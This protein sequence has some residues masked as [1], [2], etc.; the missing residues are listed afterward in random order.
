M[1]NMKHIGID[2]GGTSIKGAVIENGAVTAR[3]KRSTDTSRGRDSIKDCIFEVIKSLL[4][5][6]G[7]DAGIGIGSAGDID[8]YEGKVLYA[9]DNLPGFT[10]FEIKK[11]VESA[12]NRR[13]FVVNEA[14]AAFIGESFFG[15]AKDCKNA[16]MLTLGT[17]LGGAASINGKLLT[18]SNFHAARIGHIPLH[19]GGREC[20][21]GKIGCAEQYVSATGLMRTA[22]ELDC[23]CFNCNEVFKKAADGDENCREAVK[24]F[25]SDFCTVA[26][27]VKCIFDPDC[28]VIGGGLIELKQYWLEDFLN[29]LPESDAKLIRP[30]VLGN[31]AGA[32][33]AAYLLENSEIL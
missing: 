16:V 29:A 32:I 27:T 13:S 28:I 15:A 2:I 17:G 14:V 21:C 1:N 23:Q 6:I 31:D 11:D 9:T 12:F 25:I 19:I 26:D 30:A 8:P 4:P 33:G 24:L 18:G 20:T 3:A 10:G 7:T 22:N 5:L